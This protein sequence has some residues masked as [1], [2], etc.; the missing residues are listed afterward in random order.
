MLQMFVLRIG[1][2]IVALA[3][4]GIATA[5]CALALWLDLHDENYALSVLMACSGL[6]SGL[7]AVASWKLARSV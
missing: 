2:A 6:F 7:I 4:G 5:T 3:F 1:C